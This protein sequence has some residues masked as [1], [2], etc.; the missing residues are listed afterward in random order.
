MIAWMVSAALA[1]GLPAGVANPDLDAQLYRPPVDADGLL[2]TDTARGIGPG[3]SGRAV[4]HYAHRPFAYQPAE[5]DPVLLLSSAATL[6]L[7]GAYAVGPARFAL[8]VP[9]LYADG[10]LSGAG[11][12]L[13]DVALDA[14][15]TAVDAGLV[16]VG[17]SGRL[18]LPTTTVA[19]PVGT[20]GVHGELAAIVEADAE[21]LLVA[22]N[23]GMLFQPATDLIEAAWDEQLVWRLGASYSATDAVGV[24][25]DVVGS[26][27]LSTLSVSQGAAPIEALVGAWGDVGGGVRLQGGVGRGLTPGIG[28]SQLRV[29]AMIAA[30]PDNRV[31][32]D[33]DGL[34]GAADACPRE[35]EDRD[36]IRDSDG[37]PDA[38]IDVVLTVTGKDGSTPQAVQVTVEGSSATPDGDRRFLVPV[39]DQAIQVTV[40]AR[41]FTP[42]RRKLQPG[43]TEAT[44]AL[45]P[46]TRLGI[47]EVAATVDGAPPSGL[48]VWVDGEQVGLSGATPRVALPPGEHRVVVKAQGVGPAF[49]DPVVEPG[50]DAQ[51]PLALAAPLVTVEGESLVLARPLTVEDTELLRALA[52]T[53]FTSEEVAGVR[54][55]GNLMKGEAVRNAL[56]SLGVGRA[57][58]TNVESPE[59]PLLAGTFDVELAE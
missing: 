17:L 13:G 32:F 55:V 44:I 4:M 34:I 6:D 35:A 48:R 43:Q 49:A 19:A 8:D 36:G 26:A 39:D 58:V 3:L 2:W 31:D 47:V 46:R 54:L 10:D 33:G 14:R 12:G 24:S 15:V 28:A 1:Q 52:A 57:L 5:G 38:A 45:E 22:A 41:G 18:G 40:S 37:C 30:V 9:V 51:V 23:V 11:V 7:I 56:V 59:E 42:T 27:N 16:G 53:L 25:G 29:V 50:Q 21:P 20:P